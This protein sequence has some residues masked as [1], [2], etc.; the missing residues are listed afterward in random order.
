MLDK[1]SE[2]YEANAIAAY[3][4]LGK[5]PTLGARSL[6]MLQACHR[7]GD[8]L[9]GDAEIRAAVMPLVTDGEQL[10]GW[11]QAFHETSLR[12][13]AEYGENTEPISCVEASISVMARLAFAG[14]LEH[15]TPFCISVLSGCSSVVEHDEFFVG[16]LVFA[17]IANDLADM[18]EREMGDGDGES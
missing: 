12:I 1:M 4:H 8:R 16:L 3:S 18:Q 2:E 10:P 6:R 15:V 7:T 13:I 5:L 14:A 9:P 17:K 11:Y